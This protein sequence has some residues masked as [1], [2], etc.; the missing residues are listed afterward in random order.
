MRLASVLMMSVFGFSS[1]CNAVEKP[2]N[3]NN[4]L[5]LDISIYNQNL[6]LVKDVRRVPLEQGNNDIAFEGVAS[7]I[8]PETAILYADGLKVLEQN[9]DYDLLTANNMVD[10]SV[11]TSVKT[12]LMNPTTGE[13]I[14]NKAKIISATYGMPVL[15]FD[16]GIEANFPGRIVFE[17]LPSGLRSKPTLVAKVVSDKTAEKDLSLAYLTNGIS[18]KTNYVAKVNT[19][20]DRLGNYK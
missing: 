5:S 7:N 8:K 17:N 14:Y 11:G 9:Y 3:E 12:V 15:E 18:W 4:K 20:F 6:A 2:I 13:N 19:Q 16:Y 10:K 1:L